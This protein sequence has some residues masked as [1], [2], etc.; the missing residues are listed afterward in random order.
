MQLH[1]CMYVCM[2]MCVQCTV[3]TAFY[4]HPLVQQKTSL[5]R[6]VVCETR[7]AMTC[8]CKVNTFPSPIHIFGNSLKTLAA[9]YLT[10]LLFKVYTKG[11]SKL[12]QTYNKVHVYSTV[13]PYSGT[14]TC[15]WL[16][17]IWQS[18]VVFGR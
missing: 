10:S 3:E 9:V 7:V 8:P 6:Q 14:F 12:T 1:V 2:Y 15:K 18:V 11:G 16:C 17:K 4:G 13:V 5:K